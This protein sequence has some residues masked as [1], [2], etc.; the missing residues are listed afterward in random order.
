MQFLTSFAHSSQYFLG[1]PPFLL[2]SGS[3]NN[4]RHF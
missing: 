1:V 4:F 2:F 3:G